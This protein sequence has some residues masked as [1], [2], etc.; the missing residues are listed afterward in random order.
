M[1]RRFKWLVVVL[2][3]VGLAALAVGGT[4]LAAGPETSDGAVTT[5]AGEADGVLVQDCTGSGEMYRWGTGEANGASWGEPSDGEGPGLMNRWAEE[6]G[7]AGQCCQN[8]PCAGT[9][10]SQ[11]GAE[12]SN[13][14]SWGEPSDGAGP[15]LMNQWGQQGGEGA[16]WG[17]PS[18]GTGPGDMHQWGSGQT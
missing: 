7:V 12:E 8:G 4:V 16:G 9:C 13:G 18:D 5:G 3:T 14:A 1:G 10:Q 11:Q 17:E 2:A 6:P 15:G